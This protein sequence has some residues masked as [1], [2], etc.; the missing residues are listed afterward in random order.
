M[1]TL[2]LCC[3]YAFIDWQ[4]HIVYMEI[5]F[6]T[7]KCDIMGTNGRVSSMVNDWE[8]FLGDTLGVRPIGDV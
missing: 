4:L 3:I 8:V 1:A 7:P 5:D 6:N 2:D